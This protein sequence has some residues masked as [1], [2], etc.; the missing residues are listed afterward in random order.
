MGTYDT[1][2]ITS[3]VYHLGESFC[4]VWLGLLDANDTYNVAVAFSNRIMTYA[5]VNAAGTSTNKPVNIR[6]IVVR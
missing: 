4:S 1:E 6:R 5:T 2:P 3:G